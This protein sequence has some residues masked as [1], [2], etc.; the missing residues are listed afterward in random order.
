VN[1]VYAAAIEIQAFCEGRDW[2]FCIIGGLA[3]L[4]WGEPRGTQDVD[5]SLLTPLGK[6]TPFIE[7]LVG[8]FASRIDEPVPYALEN[9]IVLLTASNGI[10]MDVGLGAFPFEERMIERSSRFAFLPDV[11]LRTCSA[12]DLVVLKAIAGRGRDWSDIEGVAVVQRERLDWRYVEEVL[13]SLSEVFDSETALD[14]LAEIRRLAEE[15]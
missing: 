15:E 13:S 14:R 8:G 4:R 3:V 7:E 10:T 5:V 12:E 11:V 1:G 6:E 2:P 9:R